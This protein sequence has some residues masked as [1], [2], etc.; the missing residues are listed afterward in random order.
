MTADTEFAEY[1]TSKNGEMPACLADV[2]DRIRSARENARLEQR[3]LAA[4]VGVTQPGVSRWEA[5][6]RDCGVAGLIRVA[7]ACGVPASS[8]LPARH[9]EAGPDL[10]EG[11]WL[12]IAFMGHV[13]LTGYV[14][15]IT[16]G[17]QPAFHVDLP[18]KLW[19]GNPMAW[20]EY[21]GSAL[22]SRRP[23]SEESVRKAWEAQLERARRRA[24]QEA[25]WRA[26]DQVRALE[27]GD[28]DESGPF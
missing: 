18:E 5:G 10:G 11:Q 17:G 6:E 27:A 7:E 9:Q 23:V 13:E 28:D 8:L 16:L 4:T 22:Y 15:E 3:A 21:A 2:G 20:E 24:E 19:G 14:T 26:Q 1:V 12:S 25:A